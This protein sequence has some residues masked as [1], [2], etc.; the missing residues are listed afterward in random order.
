MVECGRSE[1]QVPNKTI[2]ACAAVNDRNGDRFSITMGCNFLTTD[3]VLVGI[4]P[5][6]REV[7]KE[8]MGDCNN[9]VPVIVYPS[10]C[11][12]TSRIEGTLTMLGAGM[13]A[14]VVSRGIGFRSRRI[15]LGS[16]G[17]W[18]GGGRF[19]GGLWRL[20]SRFFL[21]RRRCLL[22]WSWGRNGSRAT[23]S[24]LASAI[25][26]ASALDEVMTVERARIPTYMGGCEDRSG[27]K[28]CEEQ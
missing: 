18:F 22:D 6:T 21:F 20:G 3:R 19:W 14:T 26:L 11:A 2:I 17:V 25:A 8:L 24:R 4:I 16:R 7:V 23:G 5:G 1:I 15:W 10:T 12:E 13:V 28:E 9:E 27:Q